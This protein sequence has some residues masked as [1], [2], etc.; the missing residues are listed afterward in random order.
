[1]SRLQ[2][3]DDL[4]SLSKKILSYSKSE[5]AEV[6]LSSNE[7]SHLRYAA[8]TV[9]TSGSTSNTSVSITAVN[10]KRAGSVSTNDLSDDGLRAAVRRAE[11]IASLAPRANATTE[12]QADVSEVNAIRCREC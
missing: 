11:E 12:R 9:T 8:N 4:E 7:E 2:T 1:M 5:W 6:H 3:V 10:G